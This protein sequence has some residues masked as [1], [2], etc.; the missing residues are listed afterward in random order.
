MV[1]GWSRACVV[2]KKV[3]AFF[4]IRVR[5]SFGGR[6][7]RLVTKWFSRFGMLSIPLFFFFC[8]QKN[9]MRHAS[10][11]DIFVFAVL[12]AFAL[13]WGPA[14]GVKGGGLAAYALNGAGLATT[15]KCLPP[16]PPSAIFSFFFLFLCGPTKKKPRKLC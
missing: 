3:N 7:W 2:F 12:F 8:L 16:P 1:S 4:I 9:Y 14:C 5:L 10:L 6:A 15:I 13:K 11:L